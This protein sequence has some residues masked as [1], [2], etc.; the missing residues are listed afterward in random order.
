MKIFGKGISAICCLLVLYGFDC[1]QSS[2]LTKGDTATCTGILVP[3]LY[4]SQMRETIENPDA[5]L[6]YFRT[7]WSFDQ[8]EFQLRL[9]QATQQLAVCATEVDTLRA[10]ALETANLQEPVVPWYESVPFVVTITA[11]VSVGFAVGF[12]ALADHLAEQK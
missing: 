7:R 8:Q 12:Y 1:P 5:E 2:F 10:T 11:V 4:L 6:D 9:D 3:E